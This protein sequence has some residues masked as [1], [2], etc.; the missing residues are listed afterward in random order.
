MDNDGNML[1]ASMFS[2]KSPVLLLDF[3]LGVVYPVAV[4]FI[5][6]SVRS[7]VKSATQDAAK[8]C[9][10][11][12][13]FMVVL[14]VCSLVATSGVCNY[15]PSLPPARENYS[16]TVYTHTRRH[17]LH[18]NGSVEAVET[19][20]KFASSYAT[21]L[22]GHN[23]SIIRMMMRANHTL[24]YTLLFLSPFA[25]LWLVRVLII[26]VLTGHTTEFITSVL[27]VVSSR[28]GATHDFSVWSAAAAAGAGV[29]FILLLMVRRQ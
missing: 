11:A 2:S 3:I 22:D 4:P 24:N 9:E 26:A 14:A 20:A 28:H 19:V 6:F 15:T 17:L 27:L 10:F 5:F 12:M 1:P 18:K 29:V 8:L 23:V 16:E 21:N 13:P 25:A 7:T